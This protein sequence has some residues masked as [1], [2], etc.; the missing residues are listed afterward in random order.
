MKYYW[1]YDK[2]IQRNFDF[3][4]KKFQLNLANYHTEH[5]TAAYHRQIRKK[6]LLDFPQ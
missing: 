2:H 6:Y 5:F 4:W 3:I 1:L